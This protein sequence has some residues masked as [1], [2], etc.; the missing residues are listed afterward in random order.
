MMIF[1]EG[2]IFLNLDHRK[3]S[4]DLREKFKNLE[5]GSAYE[6]KKKETSKHNICNFDLS[7]LKKKTVFCIDL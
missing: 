1:K 7:L 2:I 4:I 6:L 5:N 3:R